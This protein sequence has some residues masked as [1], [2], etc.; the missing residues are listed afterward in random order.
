MAKQPGKVGRGRGLLG[1]KTTAD[2]L[3][4][5]PSQQAHGAKQQ[6]FKGNNIKGNARA[7]ISPTHGMNAR[8]KGA[9]RD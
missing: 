3:G 4:R 6:G 7:N 8:R 5:T 9:V 2:A 1:D